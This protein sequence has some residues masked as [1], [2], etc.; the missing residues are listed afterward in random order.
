MEFF[1]EMSWLILMLKH[2]EEFVDTQRERLRRKL[3]SLTPLRS[4]YNKKMTQIRR[5]NLGHFKIKLSQF[6]K[7]YQNLK[8]INFILD[9]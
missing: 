7:S 2:K 9:L 8:L 4:F 1:R 6:V 5:I 3:A